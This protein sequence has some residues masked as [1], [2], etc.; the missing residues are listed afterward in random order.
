MLVWMAR[1]AGYVWRVTR[2]RFRR[3]AGAGSA[4]AAAA[5]C[6]STTPSYPRLPAHAHS[7][8]S[9]HHTPQLPNSEIEIFRSFNPN[10]SLQRERDIALG[11]YF[12]T[13]L[14]LH[15]NR[16]DTESQTVYIR[17]FDE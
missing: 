13:R 2:G 4:N 8:Y 10:P 16:F 3:R 14:F 7:T 5:R 6:R 17:K 11:V 15:L 12:H 9:Q 1:Q